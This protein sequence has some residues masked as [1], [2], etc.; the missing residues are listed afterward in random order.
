MDLRTTYEDWSANVDCDPEAE[1]QRGLQVAREMRHT[2]PEYP[3]VAPVAFESMRRSLA[4]LDASAERGSKV[5]VAQAAYL[6]GQL[7]GWQDPPFTLDELLAIKAQRPTPLTYCLCGS[8]NKAAGAFARE[9][10]RLTL[11]GHKVLSIG[12]NARDADLGI[13]WEQKIRLDLLHLAKIDAADVVLILNVENYIG[14]STR[15]EWEYARRL[16]KQIEF[17]EPPGP[18]FV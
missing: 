1:Y 11:A 7:A 14:E 6:R 2:S 5:A 13:T 8:T 3:V 18:D 15:R 10:L 17:L 9:S 12:V 4:Q 16:G